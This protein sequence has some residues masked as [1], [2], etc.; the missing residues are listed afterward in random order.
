[1]GSW[2]GGGP[3]LLLIYH[4][5]EALQSLVT[6]KC[7]KVLQVLENWCEVLQRLLGSYCVYRFH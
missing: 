5:A 2:A 7:L 4:A 1:M 3:W 6:R